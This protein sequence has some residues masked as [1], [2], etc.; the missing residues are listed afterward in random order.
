MG[1]IMPIRPIIRPWFPR[2]RPEPTSTRIRRPPRTPPSV[3]PDDE[4][5]GMSSTCRA[6]TP[7][8]KGTNLI[9]GDDKRNGSLDGQA[10]VPT[11]KASAN[12][13]SPRQRRPPEICSG[14]RSRSPPAT[15]LRAREAQEELLAQ[16]ALTLL[17][18]LPAVIRRRGQRYSAG[19]FRRRRGCSWSDRLNTHSLP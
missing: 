2:R 3:K 8:R 13:C 4:P 6:A 16:E 11:V 14:L 18:A 17:I 7:R 9:A 12:F 10:A 5:C 1:D 15:T 19:S